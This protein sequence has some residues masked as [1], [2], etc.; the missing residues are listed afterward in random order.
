MLNGKLTEDVFGKEFPNGKKDDLFLETK[1]K[2]EKQP[3]HSRPLK[4]SQSHAIFL[5]GQNR[6]LLTF[7]P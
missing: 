4:E 2:R 6:V 1:T 3:P 5:V 7:T